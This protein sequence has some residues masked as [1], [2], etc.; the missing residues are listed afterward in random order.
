MNIRPATLADLKSITKIYNE[1][2]VNTTATFDTEPKTLAK[3]RQWFEHH[4]SGYPVL[5]AEFNHKVVGWASLS[6]WSD[7]CAYSETAEASIYVHKDYRGKGI[8]KKLTEALL[9][10][11]R[12]AG[13]HTVIARI[14]SEN[15][16]SLR[17]AKALGFA[18]IG[19][20]RE[21]GVKFGRR[22]DVCMLQIILDSKS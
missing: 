22:L 21:V 18:D 9:E 12:K 1:A 14:T 15:T 2:V 20:M 8:G 5:V 16:P 13:L 11:G 19:T 7:R 6:P 10:A 17:L 4:S 3:Q